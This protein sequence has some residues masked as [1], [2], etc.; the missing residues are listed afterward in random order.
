[1]SRRLY[2]LAALG[3]MALLFYLSHQPGTDAPLQF[4]GQDKLFHALAYAILGGLLMAAMVPGDNG[5]SR[6]QAA[7]AVLLAS[8]YGASDEF[9][10][11]FIPGRSAETAD[12]LAD[13]AGA[14]AAVLLVTWLSRRAAHR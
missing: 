8:L 1:M 14:L 2:L 5:F 9:H 3:W 4:Y 6:A 11:S 7:L 13:S 12:W 10:Q